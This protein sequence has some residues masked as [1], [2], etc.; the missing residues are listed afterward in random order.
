M[1][2]DKDLPENVRRLQAA[3]GPPSQAGFGSAVFHDKLG[4]GQELSGLA[5]ET[6]RH[7]VGELWERWG[8]QTW[9]GPWKEVYARPPGGKPDIVAEL[10]A[11]QDVQALVS[12]P[13]ILDTVDRPDAA[14]SALAGVYDDPSVTDVRVFNIGDGEA[15]SGLLVAG[16]RAGNGETTFLVFLMD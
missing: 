3:Y 14:R 16:S 8:E 15:M 6:Y 11:I 13:M 4:A 9:M 5:R 7:F 12:V 1:T 10:R 2:A